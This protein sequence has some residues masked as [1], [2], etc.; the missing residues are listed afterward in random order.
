M[1]LKHLKITHWKKEWTR[2]FELGNNRIKLQALEN[3]WNGERKSEL[4][5]EGHLDDW[6]LCQNFSKR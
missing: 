4:N 6:F 1:N 3:R 2:C 5:E